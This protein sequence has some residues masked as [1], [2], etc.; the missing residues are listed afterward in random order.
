MAIDDE[1]HPA[2]VMAH[3]ELLRRLGLVLGDGRNPLNKPFLD[4]L[5]DTVKEHQRE[6]RGRGLHFPTMVALVVPRLGIVE[7]KRADLDISSIRISIVNFVRQHAPQGVKMDE[8]VLAFRMAWP[9]LKPD[10]ILLGHE[11]AVAANKRQAERIAKHISDFDPDAG[12]G[13]GDNQEK[14][15]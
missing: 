3:Q 9:D 2:M 11:K 15:E 4:K 6:C 13:T 14:S 12:A 10:D 5:Y 8:V 1:D 7:F